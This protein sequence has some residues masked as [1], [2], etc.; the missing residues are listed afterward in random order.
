MLFKFACY[1][2]AE[3]P[4]FFSI[5]IESDEWVAELLKAI[6]KELKFYER[7]ASE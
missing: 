5:K 4:L 7:P 3:T 2:P 6:Q 1:F